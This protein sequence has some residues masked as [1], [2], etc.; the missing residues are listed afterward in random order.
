MISELLDL[1]PKNLTATFSQ[2]M[3][4][5]AASCCDIRGWKPLPPNKNISFRQ[6]VA[7]AVNQHSNITEWFDLTPKKISS[8]SPSR[9]VTFLY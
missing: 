1:I 9:K 3:A 7:V 2:F 6:S 4:V 5:G 8:E